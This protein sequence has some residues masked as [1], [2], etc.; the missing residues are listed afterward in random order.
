MTIGNTSIN[1]CSFI[2]GNNNHALSVLRIAVRLRLIPNMYPT[3][4][5]FIGIMGG[6][7]LFWM[8]IIL[9]RDIRKP[10]YTAKKT[11]GT[12][13][14]LT[15][16]IL[17]ASNP[18]F[19]IWWITIGIKL[20]SQARQLG[21]FAFLLFTIVHWLC[22]LTWFAMLSFASF[23]GAKI[24]SDRNLKIILGICGIALLCYG[25]YFILDAVNL[26]LNHSPLITQ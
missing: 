21:F 9:V 7:F 13:P 11:Y 19:L 10:G 6:V 12:N 5:I 14:V 16:M 24:M 17:S 18:Y 20:A 23:K 1:N 4:L 2:L 22:D 8:G 26:W 15:G 25:G 3:A